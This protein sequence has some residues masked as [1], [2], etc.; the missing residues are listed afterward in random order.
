MRIKSA[1]SQTSFL[2]T[3][4]ILWKTGIYSEAIRE[5]VIATGSQLEARF[6]PIGS[7]PHPC[8]WAISNVP[9]TIPIRRHS[10][11]RIPPNSRVTIHYPHIGGIVYR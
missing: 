11:S 4:D 7:S 3:K 6:T 9:I 8:F 5:L 2:F 10:G 1:P